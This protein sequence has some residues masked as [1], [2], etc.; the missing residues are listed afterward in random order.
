M[1]MINILLE[2]DRTEHKQD[3][4]LHSILQTLTP[5]GL[6]TVHGSTRNGKKRKE[7]EHARSP[8]ASETA[9]ENSSLK[10]WQVQEL[11]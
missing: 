3:E 8:A 2:R 9:L 1:K 7:N 5:V 6:Q 10:T 11:G 4:R